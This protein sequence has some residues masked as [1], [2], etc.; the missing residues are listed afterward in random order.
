LEDLL[1][2]FDDRGLCEDIDQFIEDFELELP[3][4]VKIGKPL[5]HKIRGRVPVI[6]GNH[7]EHLEQISVFRIYN[8]IGLDVTTEAQPEVA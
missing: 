7:T 1:R 2:I 8:L 6:L 5:E 4:V 3:L